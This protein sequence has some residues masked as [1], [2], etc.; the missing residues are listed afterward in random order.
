M[1]MKIISLFSGAGGLDLG[2]KEAG[3]D[4]VLA[5]DIMP[6]AE[7]TYK[8]NFP[9]AKFIKKDIRLLGVNEIKKAIGNQKIDVI[10][11]GPPC[12]GFSNM[13]NHNSADPKNY[14]F[15]KYVDIVNAIQPK[16][17]VFE[18]V[19]G[20]F[21][22][23][24]GRFFDK[25]VNSFLEIG[26]D[27]FY[28]MIDSSDYGV[29]QKRERIIIVG[30][31][32][33]RP[34]KFPQPD[35]N[36]FGK[37]TS[38]KN[39]G[40]AINNL[41]KRNK[42]PNHIPLNHSE[43]VISRYKLIPEG[44]KLPKPENLPKEIRR[45]NFG[46]TYTRLSRNDVSSTI[47][48]GNN[49]LPVHPTLN[50][51]LTAREAARIQT[52]PDDFV[53]EGD[54]RSQCILVGNAVPPLLS[55]KI[56]ESVS[57]FIKGKKYESIEPDGE[58]HVGET[59]SR[60]KNNPTKSGR[61][62][63]KFA[64]LFCGAGGFTQGLESAGL[65][66]VL[67]VDNDEHAVAAYRLNHKHHECL[68]LDLS[69]LEN[70]KIISRQLKKEGVDLI[71][72]GPPCQGFSIFGKRRFVNTRKHD[73]KSDKRNDLVFAYANIIK[74][75]KPNWF[76]ME[77]VPGIISARNGTYIDTIR[78]FFAKNKYRTEIKI[79]N[80]ADYGVPQ[81]RKRF[82]LFGTKTDLMIPWPKPKFFENPESWQ[83]QHRTV[84]EVLNDL[85]N[86]STVGRYKNHFVPSHTKVVSERF[87]YIKEGEKLNVESLP[88]NLKIGEKTGKPI[89]NY[90]GVYRRLHR[91]KPSNTIVPGHNALPVHP[92]L[93]RTLTI[94]EAA[95]IQTFPD[96]FEFVGP[97]VQ[98]GLQVGNAF[99][100][101]VA[102]I[103]GE[104]LRTVV[105]RNW[106]VDRTTDLAK[107]SML[108]K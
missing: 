95:R 82:I 79:I 93:N 94:R 39:V 103:V 1:I 107:Y 99:P 17:F 27:I 13:G 102:Q 6:H 73:I 84:G 96:N 25:I 100:C 89:S 90:S 70:Q 63:L 14:L 44:G 3:F 78:K 66:C 53:F 62:T 59:F 40:K 76:I 7:S 16:C 11:G 104:R 30:S 106:N 87:S 21:T 81:K 46:N 8:K 67:G 5:S 57:N 97:I 50:R 69:S 29:P 74:N 71:V 60:T 75:V 88:N 28:R 48:P 64:D 52:F 20:L 86:K 68:K 35:A 38:Y 10:I 47:V 83:S 23:F 61:A 108:E 77:N 65:Q 105:N 22:M 54:R 18:N 15:E 2:F 91:D 34:F 41:V 85:S 36:P 33:D 31:K 101:L 56:A 37:I 55:A 12:Q 51:S 24:E 26:Y 80:A 42:M 49:A 9:E 92:T 19:K 43:V 58:A 98:Q 4:C 32:I 72:G 45:R